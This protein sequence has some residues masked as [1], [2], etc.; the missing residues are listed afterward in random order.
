MSDVKR[1]LV[2]L[3]KASSLRRFSVGPE[4]F[5]SLL[6]NLAHCAWLLASSCL[7]RFS[8]LEATT[9]TLGAESSSKV[10]SCRWHKQLG[11]RKAQWLSLGT[12]LPLVFII[13]CLDQLAHSELIAFILNI[14]H[15]TIHH[16]VNVYLRCYCFICVFFW[17]YGLVS[18]FGWRWT[19]WGGLVPVRFYCSLLGNSALLIFH[20]DIWNGLLVNLDRDCWLIIHLLIFFLD[21]KKIWSVLILRKWLETSMLVQLE[22]VAVI[23]WKEV[24]SC[25][26]AWLRTYLSHVPSNGSILFLSH[27]VHFILGISD[28]LINFGISNFLL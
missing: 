19:A 18:F 21:S 20:V 15:I 17:S 2:D 23:N 16:T 25:V 10:I 9:S 12:F 26:L 4:L 28:D 8:I 22:S 7:L 24:W 27:S 13:I 3:A 11:I 14:L 1:L 6:T 5:L